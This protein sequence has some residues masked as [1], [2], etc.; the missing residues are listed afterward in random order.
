[1]TETNEG[2]SGAKIVIIGGSSGIGLGAAK[3]LAAA[4]A[5]VI[6]AG[7]DAGRLGTAAASIGA[8]ARAEACD[9]ADPKSCADLFERLGRIDHLVLTMTGRLGGGEFAALPLGEL[10]QAFEEKFWP[11]LIAAQTSLKSLSKNGSLTFVTGIS[12]RKVNPG[13]SGFA[14]INGALEIM[15]PTLARELAPLR[16]NAVSP[17]LIETPWYDFMPYPERQEMYANAAASLPV[18]RVGGA[19]DVARAIFYVVATPFVT[20]SVVECDGGARLTGG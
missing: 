16:V 3:M 15:T 8:S 13:G 7:R 1:M 17:G 19:Q 10:R 9:A 5:E 20:G 11:H 4:G 6:I 2:I 18:G 14:A 12:A